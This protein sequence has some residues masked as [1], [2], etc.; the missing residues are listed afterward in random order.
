M[1]ELQR[2]TGV[3][4]RGGCLSRTAGI[5]TSGPRVAYAPAEAQTD[6]LD[7]ARSIQIGP[8]AQEVLRP[9]LRTAPDEHLFQPREAEAERRAAQRAARKTKVQLSQSDRRKPA[10]RKRPRDRYGA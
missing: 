3:R 4:P 6:H 7:R 5:G 10:P 1:V 2:W 8:R 9:W